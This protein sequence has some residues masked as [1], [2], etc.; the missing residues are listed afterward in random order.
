MKTVTGTSTVAC[1]IAESPPHKLATIKFQRFNH[2]P[3]LQMVPWSSAKAKVS[4]HYVRNRLHYLIVDPG[5]VAVLIYIRR[6][7]QQLD[8]APHRLSVQR[9]RI[10]QDKKGA[11]AKSARR[12]IATLIERGK[13]ETARV[14]TE[15]SV[16]CC[17]AHIMTG[18][19]YISRCS[20]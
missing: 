16:S 8:H 20:H 10:L 17:V 11:Q 19:P 7:S 14:K 5:P 12:D 15:N 13:L 18:I 3:R 6:L 4:L 2:D 1:R 9:L